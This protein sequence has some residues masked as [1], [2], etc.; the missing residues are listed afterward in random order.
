[1]DLECTEWDFGA[2]AL[3]GV[4]SDTHRSASVSALPQ[5]LL[6]H[7][8]RVDL[9]LHA[10]DICHP[11][12]LEALGRIAPVEA[13]RGN[14]DGVLI[15]RR[16]PERRLVRVGQ[17]L[18]GLVHGSGAPDEVPTVAWE[19]FFSSQEALERPDALVFG[20]SHRP[21]C[22]SR[23]GVLL[24][25]PG[26]PTRPADDGPSCA[27]LHCGERLTGEIVYL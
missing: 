18:I 23:Q 7:L 13:V 25:N 8:Q 10:G 20:H 26:S 12:V 5:R 1:M 24:L 11:V 9:I 22:M 6:D 2:A 3:V 17:W 4:V 21:L 16:L 15:A 14:M 19:A 27:L